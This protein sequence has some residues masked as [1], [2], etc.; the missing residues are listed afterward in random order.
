MVAQS[1]CSQSVQQ[2]YGVTI[3]MRELFA[4]PQLAAVAQRIDAAIAE[5]GDDMHEEGVL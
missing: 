3:A 1:R 4:R 5:V 2:R